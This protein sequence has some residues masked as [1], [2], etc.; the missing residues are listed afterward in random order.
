MSCPIFH[1]SALFACFIRGV[2]PSI[3]PLK[4]PA[5]GQKLS[6]LLSSSSS[7]PYMAFWLKRS[8]SEYFFYPSVP[9][10]VPDQL[11]STLVP[12][13]ITQKPVVCLI[14]YHPALQ[15]S[16]LKGT[17]KHPCASRP[18]YTQQKNYAITPGIFEIFLG[19]N[20]NFFFSQKK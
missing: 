9:I 10:L 5:P 18:L 11:E 1:Y 15:I 2:P 12:P 16:D 14:R 4:C 13:S 3:N 20:F 8:N 7:P 19:V 6:N 17:Y